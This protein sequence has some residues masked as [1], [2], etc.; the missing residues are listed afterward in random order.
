M[1]DEEGKGGARAVGVEYYQQQHDD[2]KEEEEDKA[3]A[4]SS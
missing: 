3:L 4:V 2:D 1:Q